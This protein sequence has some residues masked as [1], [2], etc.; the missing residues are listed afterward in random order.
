M[1][2]K[3]SNKWVSSVQPRKQRKYRHNAPLHVRHKF[4]SA[5]LSKDLRKR[6]GKRSLPIR[7]GDEV[8]VTRG[9][10]KKLKGNVTRV[11][12][13]RLKVY[14][15]EIKVKKVDGS[16]ITKP[17]EPSNLRITKLSLDDKR[18]QAVLERAAKKS[19]SESKK[20]GQKE[21]KTKPKET[22]KPERS[23]KEEK[24]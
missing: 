11:D 9:S 4:L 5:N 14:V 24:K 8:E 22:P 17:L 13:T 1:R 18:R 15:D 7:Q 2:Q 16:E 6:Y 19:R 23:E 21:K 3:W 20:E 10:S 12:L